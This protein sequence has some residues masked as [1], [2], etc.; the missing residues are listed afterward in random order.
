MSQPGDR[1]EREAEAMADLVAGSPAA[2]QR[3]AAD[4]GC[5]SAP[6]DDD[7]QAIR[8]EEDA[9]EGT[10]MASASGLRVQPLP[11]AREAQL[12]A[13][14]GEGAALPED[15]RTSMEPHFGAD[16]GAVRV[17][18]DGFADG[19][20]R[21]VGAE[22]FTTGADI[23]F[24]AGRYEPAS[25]QGRRL[26]AHELTHVVQQRRTAAGPS[27]SRYTVSRDV[28]IMLAMA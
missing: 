18:T 8:S 15:V 25:G 4:G 12:L 26:I 23:Y 16:F 7:P 5:S 28:A 2:V 6:A 11:A 10:M 1:V 27:I 22:A 14:R 19:L 13:S 24:R 20:N 21:E 9:S 17:H 3:K